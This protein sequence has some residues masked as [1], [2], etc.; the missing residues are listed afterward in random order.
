[1]NTP[2]EK[3]ICYTICICQMTAVL[4]CVSLVYLT[5]AIYSPAYRTLHSGFLED[6]VMCTTISNK[7][8]PNCEV[9]GKSSWGSCGEWCL[10]KS[11]GSCTQILVDV[12]WNGTNIRLEQCSAVDVKYCDGI[13]PKMEVKSCIQG[14]CSELHGIYNCST[15]ASSATGD[16]TGAQCRNLTSVLACTLTTLDVNKTCNTKTSCADLE[17]LYDCKYGVCAKILPPYKCDKRCISIRTGAKNILVRQGDIIFT[18][19]CDRAVVAET[20]QEVWPRGKVALSNSALPPMLVLFCTNVAEIEGGG[21]AAGGLKSMSLTDCFNG[22]LLEP[23]HFGNF[24][25]ITY[26]LSSHLES[27]EAGDRMLDAEGYGGDGSDLRSQSRFQCFYSPNVTQIPQDFVVLRFSRMRTI[28]EL[29][30]ASTV[31]VTL[32]IV[33]CLTLVICTRIIHVG[34]DSHFTFHCCGGDPSGGMEKEEG[35]AIMA[36]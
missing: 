12:R 16:K 33:S 22:T 19:A 31:P 6:A 2:F 30:I 27:S 18:M 21:V 3:R 14:E 9:D 10:S 8:I 7:S 20:G 13:N 26:I 34:D 23:D 29:F 5:V 11:S 35:E 4:S 36:L 17:G 28:L 32:A 15:G 25:N 24:T 1:M